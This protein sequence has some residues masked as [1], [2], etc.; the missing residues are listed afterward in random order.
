MCKIK[1]SLIG[2]ERLD[3]FQFRENHDEWKETRF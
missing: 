2:G 1:K 3:N